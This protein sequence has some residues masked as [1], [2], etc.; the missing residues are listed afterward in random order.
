MYYVLGVKVYQWD[1]KA[2][3]EKILN[4]YYVV[5]SMPGRVYTK[6]KEEKLFSGSLQFNRTRLKNTSTMSVCVF[7]YESVCFHVYK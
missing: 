1:N 7:E 4:M 3:K 6:N 5:G 2:D